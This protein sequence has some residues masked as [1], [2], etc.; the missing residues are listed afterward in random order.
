MLKDLLQAVSR[1]WQNSAC[2][3]KATAKSDV[4]FTAA[5]AAAAA[6]AAG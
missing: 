1:T 6:D 4:Y 5:A 3:N 2:V